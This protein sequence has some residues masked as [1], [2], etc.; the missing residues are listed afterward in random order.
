M[1]KEQLS[2]DE[3]TFNGWRLFQDKQHQT[4]AIAI[5]FRKSPS[6]NGQKLYGFINYANKISKPCFAVYH[7]YN[8]ELANE[9]R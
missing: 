4:V 5:C 8:N 1:Q 7:E 9:D 3:I 2:L 6:T